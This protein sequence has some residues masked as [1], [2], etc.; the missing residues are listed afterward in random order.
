MHIT[1]PS[2]EGNSK[3]TLMNEK[4]ISPK[5]CALGIELGSTRVK[6][7]L[8]G[9]DGGVVAK[10]SYTWENRFEGGYWTYSMADVETALRAAYGAL[11]AS[12]AETYGQPLTEVG[13]IGISAMMHGY[14]A[15]DCDG[16]LLVPF[17]TWRNTTCGQAAEELTEA[18]GFRMPQRWS[19]SHYYQAVLNG[20]A[21]VKDVV[22]LNTL[23]GYVHKLL[24]GRN[25]LGVG[26]AS[27]M[28]PTVG[29]AYD[30]EKLEKM[31]KLLASKGLSVDFADLL[32]EVLAAGAV[33]GYLT[34]EGAKLLDPTGNLKAGAVF[35]PPEG[36][37]GTGMVATDS[38]REATGN[39]SAG[40]SAFAM[41]VLEQP[42]DKP[43]TGIDVVATPAGKSVAMVH[44][45][46]FTSEINAWGAMFTEAA[47]L[48]GVE[49]H[50]GKMLD[51]LFEISETADDNYGGYIGYSFLAGEPVA[52]VVEGRPMILR[53]PDG[54]PNLANFM[55]MQIC[56]ALAGL[57]MG[58]KTLRSV[59]VEIRSI[60]GHGGF[61]KAG[62]PAVRAMAAAV[63]APV[64]VLTTA[65][66]GGAWGISLLALY[67]LKQE[68]T[69]EDFIDG[70][71]RGADSMT[72][73]PVEKD[74]SS[75]E[76]YL[77]RF[78]TALPLERQA[79][80]LFR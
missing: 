40:T 77:T 60:L 18:L 24:T 17:R 54:A 23:S 59:G 55:K 42:L 75:M 27:G 20:E 67:T 8:T 70:F 80:G 43:Y 58:I 35:C 46:N 52:G 37:A 56:S 50:P 38:I 73:E 69:L 1:F 53:H 6:A 76:A 41:I 47:K 14:L 2:R 7:V 64:T 39:I 79:S 61:F 31:N 25:V 36:D 9:A 29:A 62:L 66:E 21:H 74:V 11:A 33:A 44:V 30:A 45:N 5:T 4:Q 13:A 48:A 78:E 68:G 57:S 26:D 28:F 71:F 10:G 12:Y 22:S 51:R 65:D 15:F 19:A 63:K 32:P 49:I 3:E 34:E 72:A 16:K